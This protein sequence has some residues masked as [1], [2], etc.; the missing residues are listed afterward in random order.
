M[1]GGGRKPTLPH[2]EVAGGNLQMAGSITQPR[3]FWRRTWEALDERLG[4][5]S[6]AYP[7]PAHA[8]GIG[9][10]L[11]GISFMGFLILAATGIWLAQFYHATAEAARPSVLYIQRVAPLGDI[12]RGVHFWT[13]NVVMAT[14]LLHLGRIVV[15]G[16]YKRPR[17]ANWLI[18]VG[19]LVTTLAMLF[20]GTVVKWDQEG[21]EALG[22]VEEAG[23]LLGALGF[24]FA[25]EFT[26]T[27]PLLGRLYIAHI[28]ILP[29]IGALLMIAHFL[30]IKHLGISARPSEADAAVIGGPTPNPGGSSFG[31]HLIRMI[32]FGLVIFAAAIVLALVWPPTLGPQP[33][34]GE[35]VT[36]P[37]WIFL[38][39]YP[40][41]DWFGLPALLWMPGILLVGLVALPFLDR[42][43]YRSPGRRRLVIGIGVV[44]VVALVMLGVI[45]FVTAPQPHLMEGG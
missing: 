32:G 2:I 34:P 38:P 21:F 43:P 14:V 17:E 24:W 37:P 12:A 22:H 6:L 4:L 39:I 26:A 27:V 23:G 25:N 19:L 5:S 36:K 30:L 41:E 28:V 31:T 29:G 18:G 35:E 1:I 7:V 13:A 15:T 10:I 20:T 42:S 11:G 40:F 8:N 44:G 33:V 9:Y 3:G 45:A 16:S